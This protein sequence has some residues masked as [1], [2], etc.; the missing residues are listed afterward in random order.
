M[1][2]NRDVYNSVFADFYT[3]DRV[4]ASYNHLIAGRVLLSLDVGFSYVDYVPVTYVDTGVQ[5]DRQDPIVDAKLFVEYRI[6][7]F[8]A[9][10][11]TLRYIGNFSTIDLPLVGYPDDPAGFQSFEALAGVRVMY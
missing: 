7:S 11:A 4:S 3:R 8:L 2:Y 1:Q 5:I 9:I 6:R 10:N